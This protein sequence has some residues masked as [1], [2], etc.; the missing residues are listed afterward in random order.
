MASNITN[1]SDY[2]SGV[3]GR[4]GFGYSGDTSD[5]SYV[6]DDPSG[7][8]IGLASL[9]SPDDF[10]DMD[11]RGE[12]GRTGGRADFGVGYGRASIPTAQKILA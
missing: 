4:E 3:S 6:G 10:L 9:F 1:A 5:T 7:G 8:E 2:S 12:G 11:S